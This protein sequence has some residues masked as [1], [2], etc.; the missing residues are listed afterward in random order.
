[1]KK[2]LLILLTATFSLTITA[3]E[4]TK[5]KEI[6]ISFNNLNNFG[7]TYK[8]GN[9]K[10]LWR[11]NTLLISGVNNNNSRD[12][13]E[14]NRNSIGFTLKFGKEYRKEITEKLEFRYGVDLSF[15][16]RKS[17]YDYNDKSIVNNDMLD[18][19]LTY[20][21]GINFILGFNYLISKDILIGAALLPGFNYIIG[22]SN[23]LGSSNEV[24]TSETSGFD[25][26]LS[27]TSAL[28]SLSYRF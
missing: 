10:S 11:I 8:F 20:R 3:Q 24:I 21:P 16:Y 15:G 22:I 6:G 14:I 18:E 2:T 12:S 28:L 5:Q 26:G 13:L 19:K 1:M 4:K 27:N 25:Y 23:S 17:K 9:S 7:L